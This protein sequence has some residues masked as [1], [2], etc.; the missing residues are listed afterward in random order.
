LGDEAYQATQDA[1]FRM[2]LRIIILKAWYKRSKKKDE[3]IEIVDAYQEALRKYIFRNEITSSLHQ[4]RFKNFIRYFVRIW[5]PNYTNALDVLSV[6]EDI[7]EESVM[8]EKQ[9]LLEEAQ[10]LYDRLI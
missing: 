9:W 6:V 5:R 7:K 1:F 4:E 8:A 2:D 3:L 10:Q